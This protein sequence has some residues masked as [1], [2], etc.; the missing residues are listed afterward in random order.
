MVRL[1]FR[2]EILFGK[3][4][5]V[6]F[7]NL[8]EHDFVVH[9][10]P[11][12]LPLDHVEFCLRLLA[13]YH[14]G[15]ISY[16]EHKSKEL[17]RRYCLH[18]E[19]QKHMQEPLFRK[20]ENF[21]GY[22]WFKARMSAVKA[23]VHRLPF[24]DIAPEEFK[25]KLDELGEKSFE[26][27]KPH[28]RFYNVLCHGDSWAKNF[29]FRYRNGTLI[30]VK[31][32]DFQLQR[33]CPPAHDVLQLLFL[34]MNSE[35]RKKYLHPL[36]RYYHDCLRTEVKKSGLNLD[37]IISYAD[38][39]TSVNYLLPQIKLQTAFFYTFQ[40]AN[41]EFHKN[42]K[43]NLTISKNSCSAT[44]RHDAVTQLKHLV[45]HETISLEDC[46]KI[47]EK[48]L[49]T[50]DYELEDYSTTRVT[51]ISGFL[52]DHYRL[53]INLLAPKNQSFNLFVKCAP[54]SETRLQMAL[55]AKALVKE[56]FMLETLF[57]MIK[58]AN[59]V[60][61]EECVVPHYLIRV[62]DVIVFDDLKR[63]GFRAGSQRVPFNFEELLVVVRKLAI[64]HACNIVLEEH[65]NFRLNTFQDALEESFFPLDN[66]NTS[67]LSIKL[68]VDTVPYQLE[69]FP[70]L[71]FSEN[72]LRKAFETCYHLVKPSDTYRNVVCHGDLWADNI[73]MK[74]KDGKPIDCRII[75]YQ[76]LRYCPPAHDLL[77]LLY[78]TTTRARYNCNVTSIYTYEHFMDSCYS[79]VPQAVC[80]E[81]LFYHFTLTN[82]ALMK[83][84]ISD[85]QLT[86]KIF[87]EDRRDFIKDMCNRDPV[88]KAR[89]RESLEDLKEMC[90]KY[91]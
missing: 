89:M 80:Q 37:K 81:V 87:L 17:N 49:G 31:M 65:R 44:G 72:K 66:H 7:E 46:Y 4:D 73:M 28:M 27:V 36:L 1:R 71:K 42:L 53:N 20:D 24:S 88:Y 8:D 67:S 6:V 91:Y 76:I 64:Y 70:D 85:E 75:D 77:T 83:D 32:I 41:P 79:L 10:S 57:P 3:D 5:F 12:A 21:L 61:V 39:E 62:N 63:Q 90:L 43:A 78:L 2:S 69:L 15:S 19:Y 51:D 45:N 23:V 30:D 11:N 48:K 84:Y 13:K 26:I 38:F 74:Y 55:G 68:G 58:E 34:A 29:L 59:V 52:G 82:P 16:Q 14:A 54:K 56:F 25:K 50:N 60:D 22:G 40:S 18:E 47:V 35:R 86:Y 9:E 33:Y